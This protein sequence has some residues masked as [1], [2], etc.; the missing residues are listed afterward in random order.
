MASPSPTARATPSGIHIDDGY[1]TLITMSDDTNISFW[2]KSV[3]PP[4]VMGGDAI[5]TTTMH[6]SAWRTKA[7]RSLKEMGDVSCV[8]AYDPDVYTAI[9]AQLNVEQTITVTFADGTTLPVFGYLQTFEPQECAEGAQPEAN[10]TF[11]VTNYDRTNH[12]EA[13]PVLN[14]VAGT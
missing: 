1:Q 9:I 13:A 11:V 12:V 8:V 10:V 4:S 3:T 2:E 6:N 5:D 7:A 14:A